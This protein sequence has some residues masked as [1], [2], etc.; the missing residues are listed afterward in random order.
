[1]NTALQQ[2]VAEL[3]T[4]QIRQNLEAEE[5]RVDG[6]LKRLDNATEDDLEKL[7]KARMNRL[8]KAAEAKRAAIANGHGEYF[9]VFEPKDFFSQ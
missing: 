8:K 2:Q 5:A 4:G 6:M 7:R 9:E 3:V 1:M